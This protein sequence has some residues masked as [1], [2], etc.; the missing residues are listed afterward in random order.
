MIIM[1]MMMMMLLCERKSCYNF[2]ESRLNSRINLFFIGSS[3]FV[4]DNFTDKSLF[5]Y[6]TKSNQDICNAAL[7]LSSKALPWKW[8][9]WLWATRGLD[10]L[11]RHDVT[12]NLM[13]TPR[14]EWRQPIKLA[15]STQVH[16]QPIELNVRKCQKSEEHHHLLRSPITGAEYCSQPMRRCVC[17]L[18][19]FLRY[20]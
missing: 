5:S 6:P 12:T 18:K 17:R 10:T 2:N 4:S 1:M 11:G 9:Y 8:F 16:F 15:F 13:V 19:I 3:N 7:A 20:K 14:H